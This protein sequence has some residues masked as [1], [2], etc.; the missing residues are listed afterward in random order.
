MPAYLIARVDAPNPAL[1]K[2][3]MATTPPIIAQYGGRFLARGGETVTLEGAEETRR[4]VIIE[5]PS[6][7][8]AQAFYHSPEYTEARTLREGIAT[9]EFVAVAGVPGPSPT[10]ETGSAS[11]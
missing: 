8:E 7:S 4:I 3:Y 9:I 1:L 2:D 10:Q 6:L 11:K 5:F